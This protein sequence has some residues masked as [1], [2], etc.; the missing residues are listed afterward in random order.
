MKRIL[1]L[2]AG[3]GEGHNAAARNIAQA[4]TSSN[5][6]DHEAVVWNAF[7][8][9]YGALNQ[10]VER[11]YGVVIRNA[12]RIWATFFKMLNDTRLIDDRIGFLH[13]GVKAFVKKVREM[14]PHAIVTTYPGYPAL[15]NHAVRQG[16]EKK[17]PLIVQI[18]DV[19]TIN[20]VW[21]RSPADAY[22]VAND[23]TKE[24]LVA[25]GVEADRI[26]AFGFPVQPAFGKLDVKRPQPSADVR[27]RVLYIVNAERRSAIE[28]TSLLSTDKRFRLSITYGRDEILGD[29]LRK[30]LNR[31]GAR[32][33][34]YGW[35]PKLPELMATNHLILTKAGG[36]TTQEAIAAGTPLL[37]NK[38]V[39]GQEEGNARMIE[40][41]KIGAIAKKPKEILETIRSTFGHDAETW[42]TWEKN[43]RKLQKPDAAFRAAKFILKQTK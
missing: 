9:A 31:S 22:L 41:E 5:P 43:I 25:D 15:V 30:I 16:L 4:I 29:E 42:H 6:T 36:A 38:V 37:I 23:T 18:T 24:M 27:P 32:I 39:P 19:G 17:W 10:K 28:T 13:L 12:P 2:S 21:Y 20:R 33:D 40:Q 8:E 35:N 26:H 7:D 11:A 14:N 3:F 34:L 1:I